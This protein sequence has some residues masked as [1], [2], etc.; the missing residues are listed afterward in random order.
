M[1]IAAEVGEFVLSGMVGSRCRIER[2]EGATGN[3]QLSPVTLRIPNS[4]ISSTPGEL[5]SV[6]DVLDGAGS[7]V[8]D[9]SGRSKGNERTEDVLEAR[10]LNGDSC[11]SWK[12][13]SAPRGRHPSLL[14]CDRE[15]FEH[16]AI[17][18]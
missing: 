8:V 11:D 6:T 7:L 12:S 3:K 1:G 5:C 10:V 14:A 4:S 15:F 18:T 16:W 2:W 13:W 9:L 17:Q